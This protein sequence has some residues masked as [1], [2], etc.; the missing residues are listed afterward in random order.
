MSLW[1]S[2]LAFLLS[3]LVI[4]L[5]WSGHIRLFR[6]IIRNDSN[7]IWVNLLHLLFIAMIPFTASVLSLHLD[8]IVGNCIRRQ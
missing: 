1:P 2:Y 7:L 3:F 5:F 6:E 4:G 8:P